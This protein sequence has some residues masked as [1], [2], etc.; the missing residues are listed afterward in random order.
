[1]GNP[2][3]IQAHSCTS[4]LQIIQNPFLFSLAEDPSF[5]QKR[6]QQLN[7]AFFCHVLRLS[8]FSW[9]KDFPNRKLI[10]TARAAIGH[11]VF[12]HAHALYL[13]RRHVYGK[14]PLT[15]V[16]PK[17]QHA[18]FIVRH[19]LPLLPFEKAPCSGGGPDLKL[20][21]YV[22][23]RALI[24]SSCWGIDGFGDEPS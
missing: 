19:V 12:V 21:L 16:T 4:P 17:L 14:K 6:N 20:S 9:L 1:M 18:C 5:C 13:Y 11:G 24:G 3:N 2:H 10:S 8:A 23:I 22:Y 7:S 15:F